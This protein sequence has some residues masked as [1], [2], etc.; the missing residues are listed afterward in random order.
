MEQRQLTREEYK[1]DKQQD[2]QEKV[3]KKIR[4]RL[5]PIWLRLIIFAISI[6]VA[7]TVGGIVGYSVMGGGNPADVFQKD[8][9]T[10]IIELV[11]GK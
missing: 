4:I 9:W 5:I 1:Q 11:H 6:V 2:K 10:H 8:T 3:S 7:V